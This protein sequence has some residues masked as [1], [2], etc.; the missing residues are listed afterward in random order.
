MTTPAF[1]CW[2]LLQLVLFLSVSVH[3]HAF[4]PSH[5]RRSSTLSIKSSKPIFTN[6]FYDAVQSTLS[7]SSKPSRREYVVAVTST[8]SDNAAIPRGRNDTDLQQQQQQQQQQSAVSIRNNQNSDNNN[9]NCLELDSTTGTLRLCNRPD[10]LL[11]GLD[12]SV[13]SSSRPPSGTNNALFLHTAHPESAAVHHTSLGSLISC[14][15]LI[16][17]ARK[18]YILK[19]A[20][21]LLKLY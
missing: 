1:A 8:L 16:A 6:K 10:I 7:S 14:R 5:H 19:N 2:R 20:H 9:K 13:W 17:C 15:R 11:E 12:P 3:I 21:W 18:Y 4:V